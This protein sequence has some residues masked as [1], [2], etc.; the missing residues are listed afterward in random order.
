MIQNSLLYLLHSTF[1]FFPQNHINME[2]K[3]DILESIMSS[4]LMFS[5]LTLITSSMPDVELFA[6]V[7]NQEN[8]FDK[9]WWVF[10][11]FNLFFLS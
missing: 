5:K 1:Q 2:H 7:G 10:F 3:H 6:K 4:L 9:I 11:F 8:Y